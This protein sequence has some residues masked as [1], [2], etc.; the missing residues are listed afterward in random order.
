MCV[1]GRQPGNLFDNWEPTRRSRPFRETRDKRDPCNA[2]SRSPRAGTFRDRTH[3]RVFDAPPKR[4][5]FDFSRSNTPPPRPP[6][7]H[8]RFARRRAALN[9]SVTVE[10]RPVRVAS[11]DVAATA[12]AN[13]DTRYP[14]ALCC[15][16]IY[17]IFFFFF[18]VRG[19]RPYGAAYTPDTKDVLWNTHDAAESHTHNAPPRRVTRV[20]THLCT[21]AKTIAVRRPAEVSEAPRARVLCRRVFRAHVNVS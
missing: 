4:V 2:F 18:I 5:S 1:T 12:A 8:P 6:P 14:S 15:P 7:P 17:F 9:Y 13:N 20:Y 11:A 10:Y 19:P 21:R 16:R 3:L